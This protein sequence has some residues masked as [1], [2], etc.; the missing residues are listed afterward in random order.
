MNR[1]AT[2]LLVLTI[3]CAS[4][5]HGS[6]VNLYWG[7]CTG[8]GGTILETFACNSN[9]GSHTLYASFVPDMDVPNLIS[10]EAVV[11]LCTMSDPFPDWWQFAPDGCRGTAL[12]A[13][14]DFTTA[15]A[16][17]CTDPWGG[18]ASTIFAYQADSAPWN[19]A[20][21]TVFVVLLTPTSVA[22]GTEYYGFKLQIS[23]AKTVGAGACGACGTPACIVLNQINLVTADQQR[24]PM[25]MEA[26]NYTAAW[27]AMRFGCPFI[28]PTHN[29][30]WG[31][32]KGMYR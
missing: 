6:G 17:F 19:R 3:S 20:R 32:V 26:T 29:R 23:N 12:S 14:S 21:I 30:T 11:D 31:A 16:T 28:V 8:E 13:S 2:M 5:A 25:F 27:Q 1:F 4:S 15:P 10:L 24:H 22:A 18:S 7:G 9:V